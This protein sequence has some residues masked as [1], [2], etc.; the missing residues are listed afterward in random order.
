MNRHDK[1][2]LDLLQLKIQL[3]GECINCKCNELFKLEF[4]HINP[5]L[6]TKQ[7]TKMSKEEWYKEIDNI[8]LCGRQRYKW[9]NKYL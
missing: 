7:I 5:K 1:Y 3:G 8:Q 4:D 9:I 2:R 6:K